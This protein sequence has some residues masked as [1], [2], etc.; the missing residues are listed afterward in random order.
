MVFVFATT[1]SNTEKG[2]GVIL[3]AILGFIMLFGFA[4]KE[5]CGKRDALK[6]LGYTT[7]EQAELYQMSQADKDKCIKTYHLGETLYWKIDEQ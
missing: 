2:I 3:A 1:C 5:E 6:Y 4:Y 7:Y